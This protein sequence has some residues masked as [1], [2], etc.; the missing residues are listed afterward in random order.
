M[1]HEEKCTGID[2]LTCPNCKKTFSTKQAKSIHKKNGCKKMVSIFEADNVKQIRN[3]KCIK[4]YR[5]SNYT[6]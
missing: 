5:N 1:K 4:T 6:I 2:S 3:N